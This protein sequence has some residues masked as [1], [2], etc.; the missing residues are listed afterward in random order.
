MVP[1]TGRPNQFLELEEE[2]QLI[3]KA[4][5]R[6]GVT[7]AER[8]RAINRLELAYRP[9]VYRFAGKHAANVSRRARP[10]AGKGGGCVDV[11]DIYQ[12]CTEGF[13][14]AIQHFE[15]GRNARLGTVAFF[16]MRTSLQ[17]HFRSNV[18]GS[19]SNKSVS[20]VF[21]GLPALIREW[22]IDLELISSSTIDRIAKHYGVKAVVVIQALR[23]RGYITDAS[24]NNPVKNDGS[25]DTEFGDLVVDPS[26]V[27]A[28][29]DIIDRLDMQGKKRLLEEAL[30][31]L[32]PRS[33]EIFRARVLSEEKN[34]R[35]LSNLS[36]RFGVSP[37][38]IRQLEVRAIEDVAAG[39]RNRFFA[40]FAE[41]AE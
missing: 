38:R 17:V 2:M 40:K 24:M 21:H 36:E 31:D 37:E 16:W 8:Q 39:V 3:R 12:A 20:A 6:D 25:V 27:H 34:G 4:Q 18:N 19:A 7:E 13:L 10:S 15:F 23:Q 26:T 22:G 30:Q 11:S 32:T 41:A 9:L 28:E 1:N 5:G 33:R 14:Q 29:D 35:L